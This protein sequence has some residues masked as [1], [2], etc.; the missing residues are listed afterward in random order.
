L[1]L[2]EGAAFAR[3]LIAQNLVDEYVLLIYPIALGK[4]VPIFSD[5]PAPGARRA[6]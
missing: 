2:P 1:S 5:L 6:A 4:R 3:S